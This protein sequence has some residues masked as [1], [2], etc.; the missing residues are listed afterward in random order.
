MANKRNYPRRKPVLAP[1]K[2]KSVVKDVRAMK[3]AMD[4]KRAERSTISKELMAAFD[5]LL[6]K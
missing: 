4:K 5:I 3:A 2:I 1:D 6:P